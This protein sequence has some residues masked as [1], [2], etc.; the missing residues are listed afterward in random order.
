MAGSIIPLA[1]ASRM[2]GSFRTNFPNET[3]AVYYNAAVFTDIL[4]QKDCVGIRIYNAV[5]TDGNMTNV[6]VGVDE[7]GDDL[8][9]GKV[10]DMGTTCPS[11]CSLPNPLN[12]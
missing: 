11:H 6:L 9:Q 12:S 3:I 10:Y 1:V 2:T 4:S 8:Y 5:D 7:N